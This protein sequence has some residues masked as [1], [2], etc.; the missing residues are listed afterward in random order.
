MPLKFDPIGLCRSPYTDKFGI[1][2]QP[3]LITA[4]EAR[5]ELLPPYAREE[6]FDGLEG[7]SHV[8]LVFV[9]HDDCLDAG[10]KP[11][12]RPPRLGG[13]DK[14]GVF[15]SRSPYRPNPIGISAV[16]QQGL[17]RNGKHLY[18]RVAGADLLDGTPILDIKPYVPYADAIA[19]AAG[20]FAQK[21][22]GSRFEVRFSEQARHGIAEHDPD[23]RRR[24][25]ELIEQVIAQDPRPGYMDRYPERRQFSLK[26]YALNIDWE[27]DGTFATVTAI[28]AQAL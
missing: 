19:D 3:R 27:I 14:V 21:P 16:A 17:E 1:P 5:I 7:F 28:R 6:A 20:G 12:V 23:G 2:R 13:R 22:P 9:F 26:L 18:L 25:A 24:L 10:W 8:W 15:A 4:A 11:Q